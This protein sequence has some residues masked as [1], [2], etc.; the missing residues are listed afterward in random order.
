MSIPLHSARNISKESK[1]G[2]DKSGSMSGIDFSGSVVG[3]DFLY[4][5]SDD[6]VGY[7]VGCGK[8]MLWQRKFTS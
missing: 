3:I 8:W 1:M 5:N 7:A 2:K 6:S 4:W